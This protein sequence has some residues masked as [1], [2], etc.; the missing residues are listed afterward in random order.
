M[1]TVGLAALLRADYDAVSDGTA[2]HVFQTGLITRLQYA[3]TVVHIA[4]QQPPAPK[5]RTRP[6]S[7]A[8]SGAFTA[9]KRGCS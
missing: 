3:I 2:K 9:R 1:Q 8:L 7:S 5:V 6:S 4:H